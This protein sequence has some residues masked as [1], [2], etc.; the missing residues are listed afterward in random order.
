MNCCPSRWIIMI[1]L[2]SLSTMPLQAA[3]Q[4]QVLTTIQSL[5]D[6][7]TGK[8][9]L[10]LEQLK[11]AEKLLATNQEAFSQ[12]EVI[13]ASFDYVATYDDKFEPLWI[14]HEGFN[15]R[16]PKEGD[17][18]HWATFWV[19]Q[20]V[21]DHAYNNDTMTKHAKLL[22]GKKFGTAD[23]FP[24][25][26]D[27]KPNP[28]VY[29]VQINAS[30]PETWGGPFFHQDRPARKP[31]GAYLAPGSIATVT[32]PPALVN[33]GYQIRVGAHSWDLTKKP[34]VNRL[35][36]VTTLYDIDKPVMQV[37]NPLGGGIYIEVPY[38][39]DAGIVEIKIQNAVRSP[40]FSLKSFHTTTPEQWRDI[41]RNFKAPWADFQSEKNMMQLPTT[42][43]NKIEDPTPMM[44][45]WDKA[46][47]ASNYAM[48]R[49]SDFYGKETIYN[50]V[51]TQLRGRAFHPGYPAG[52][53]GYDPKE[54]YDGNH[55]HH[56]VQGPRIAHSY[57]FHE[58]GHAYL[59]PKYPGDREAAVNFPHV[60]VMNIAFDKDLDEAFRSSRS[61][62]GNPFRTLDNTAVTWM[63]IDSFLDGQDMKGYERQYQLKGH[64]KFVDVVRLF[65]WEP[66][67]KYFR[68]MN[69]D[70]MAGKPWPRNVEDTDKMTLLLSESAG[71]DL[72]PL[73]H[74]W[75]IPTQNLKATDK[76]YKSKQL[77]PSAKVYDTLIR[78]KSL[79]PKD[80]EAFR[81]FAKQWWDKQPNPEGYTTER[82]HAARWENYDADMA[83]K[84][85]ETVQQIID[86]YFPN[87]RPAENN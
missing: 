50:Q 41:E 84:T 52:N 65:G 31:T 20:H 22:N 67:H 28:D 53:R 5:K 44:K 39:A 3:D 32:V 76:L 73:I 43:V 38:K 78:Y 87:G 2:L 54:E 23:Y 49:T 35:Y 27:A 86:M 64:A 82:N 40:Y 61:M 48:G 57:E 71:V 85:Q 66:I 16:Q 4:E 51:D 75:G 7:V 42:W 9:P 63:M 80:N 74:F 18:I 21:I 72:R 77:N 17:D 79:V 62:E 58:L 14:G 8:T 6:H 15:K 36:R 12:P 68:S 56:L 60:A 55:P 46:I 30:Y 47:D 69:E 19:M 13:D 10:T 25:K 11:A 33:A 34:R 1:A 59:F 26:V 45:D 83:S 81:K 29:T 24:G 70:A 37:A